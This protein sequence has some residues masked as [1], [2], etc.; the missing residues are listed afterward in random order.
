MAFLPYLSSYL[1]NANRNGNFER[2]IFQA[3]CTPLLQSSEG[4]SQGNL[5]WNR[6]K[7]TTENS[8]TLKMWWNCWHKAKFSLSYNS[9]IVKTKT[10]NFFSFL[11][12]FSWICILWTRGSTTRK[13]C[14]DTPCQQDEMQ[15]AKK[16][17]QEDLSCLC[18]IRKLPGLFCLSTIMELSSTL[19][20][21]A[22][23]HSPATGKERLIKSICYNSATNLC[24]G[25]HNK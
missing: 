12:I 1:T 22:W 5:E 14:C 18:R 11:I 21:I 19:K 8:A 3:D 20:I 23:S 24:N 16:Q 25:T 17:K 7:N 13:K 6:D 15:D 4:F 9:Y 10:I 2:F